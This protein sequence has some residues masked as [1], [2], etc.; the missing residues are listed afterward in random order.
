MKLYNFSELVD[1]N[2]SF[3]A[4]FHPLNN[5][6]AKYRYTKFIDK[7]GSQVVELISYSTSVAYYIPRTG[8]LIVKLNVSSTT[9]Q[10]INKFAKMMGATRIL[11]CYRRKDSIIEKGLVPYANTYKLSASEFE[12]AE[13]DYFS[14]Y[15]PGMN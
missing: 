6:S 7:L 9:T 8:L 15:I 1:E 4:E 11:Y 5:C 13:R 3:T 2:M 10:H 12:K 14:A